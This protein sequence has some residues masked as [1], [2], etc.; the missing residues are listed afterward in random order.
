MAVNKKLIQRCG[1][2]ITVNIML[3]GDFHQFPP[4][5]LVKGVVWKEREKC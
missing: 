5:L 1:N 2:T 3:L 4:R